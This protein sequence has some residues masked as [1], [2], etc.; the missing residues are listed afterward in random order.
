MAKLTVAFRNVAN[1]PKTSYRE[2]NPGR[3][4]SSIVQALSELLV[5]ESPAVEKGLPT[6]D[7][8]GRLRMSGAV[9][10]LVHTPATF[11][12]RTGTTL[13]TKGK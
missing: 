7:L 6:T 1:T 9:P 11:M 2:T 12:A 10:P 8:E 3:P 13:L 5:S 4:A